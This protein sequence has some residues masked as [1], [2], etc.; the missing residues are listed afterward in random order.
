MALVYEGSA[1][2]LVMVQMI[3]FS[4]IMKFD[5]LDVVIILQAMCKLLCFGVFAVGVVGRNK[6]LMR[7]W[8]LMAYLQIRWLAIGD[9]FITIF[10]YLF[11]DHDKSRQQFLQEL[12]D[13]HGPLIGQVLT[14]FGIILIAYRFFKSLEPRKSKQYGIPLDQ[15]AAELKAK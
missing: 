3:N 12:S 5:M 11:N 6:L 2:F 9:V 7:L 8:L 15:A 1:A 14:R 10:H 13:N 4:K